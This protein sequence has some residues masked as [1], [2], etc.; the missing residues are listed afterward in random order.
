MGEAVKFFPYNNGFSSSKAYY[1]NNHMMLEQNQ[2]EE[3]NQDSWFEEVID[4]DLKW[5]FALN[6]YFNLF[7]FFI[8]S[9]GTSFGRDVYRFS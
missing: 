7:Y 4:D 8:S 3:E 9:R 5:S 1:E 6:R 2:K